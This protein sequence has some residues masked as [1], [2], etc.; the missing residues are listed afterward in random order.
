M[1]CRGTR[2]RYNSSGVCAE[3]AT[4]C[5]ESGLQRCEDRQVIT[6]TNGWLPNRITPEKLQES[7][8][9]LDKLAKDAGRDPASITI[10]VYGQPGDRGLV[11]RF[12]DAGADRVVVRPPTA[13]A[14]SEMA[15]EL[16][17]I[18]EAVL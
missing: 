2:P 4:T 18:A 7:R 11:T 16:E 10:S 8:A 14:E 13:K 9:T 3:L 17:R 1:A 6:V 5:Y 15:A 12:H